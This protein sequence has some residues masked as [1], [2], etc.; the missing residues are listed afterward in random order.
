MTNRGVDWYVTILW[1]HTPQAPSLSLMRWHGGGSFERMSRFLS[2]AARSAPSKKNM[3]FTLIEL[4]VVI[5]IIAILAALLLPALS[6]A[7][8]TGRSAVCMNNLRQLGHLFQMY[9]SDNS[10]W[11]PN[12]YE[13]YPITGWN[14]R[15][16]TLGYIAN[17]TAGKPNI[18][19][20]P[21]NK[22]RVWTTTVVTDGGHTMAYGMR[23]SQGFLAGTYYGY[24]IAGVSVIEGGTGRD[25]GPPSGFLFMADSILNYPGDPFDRFQRYWFR[26]YDVVSYAD[27]VHLRHNR[28]GNFLFGDGHVTSLASNDLVGKYGALDGSY[29]F[30]AAAIDETD[31]NF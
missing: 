27:S 13:P 28:R 30:I 23:M 17:P 7:K 20:C 16:I 31:G 15:L 9:A 11:C 18:F 25:Y 10:G 2:A 8:E 3:A 1:T 4:L 22:P 5:A 19:L 6:R 12:L 24:S 29:A 14:A 21:S 26:A